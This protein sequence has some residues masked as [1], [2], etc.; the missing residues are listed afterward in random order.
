MRWINVNET[1]P[2]VNT[3]IRVR[4]TETSRVCFGTYNPEEVI[5]FQVKDSDY[6]FEKYL[7]E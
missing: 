7:G 3:E 6:T 4:C 5:P 1:L 2:P